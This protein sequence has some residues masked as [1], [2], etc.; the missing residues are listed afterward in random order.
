MK[1][2]SIDIETTGLDPENCQ[3]L[4]IG[5]V[6]EDTN[7]QVPIEDLPS[8]HVAIL[9]QRIEGEPYALNM[10]R[11]LIQDIVYYQTAK[12]QD[13]KNDIVHFKNMKFMTDLEAVENF[14]YWL[15]ENGFVEFNDPSSGGIVTR[16]NGMLVP[17]ITRG[18][19]PIHIT[20]AGKNF[21]TFDLKFLEKLPRWKQLVKVRQR[22]TFDLK[23][24]EK[25]PRW[26]QLVKVRQ[27]IIDPSVLFTD[28]FEDESLPS[29]G[30]C[31][32]RAGFEGTVA[33][34]AL[35]DCKDIVKLLRKKYN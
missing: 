31:K 3:V 33:H 29:L 2:V 19:K 17:A 6:I 20:A 35:E 22:I 34:D 14:Y 28:W 11:D 24:L 15:A 12:D 5:A 32:E 7:N 16:R 25:L 10:N 23:F 9:R 18:T 27:R 30:Q 4:S 26:K 13:E 1:Y 21:S 8:F